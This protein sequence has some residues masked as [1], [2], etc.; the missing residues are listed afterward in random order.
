MP[1]KR[2]KKELLQGVVEQPDRVE[3][4][5]RAVRAGLALRKA[6]VDYGFL[7]AEH[8]SLPRAAV[9]QF[10]AVIRKLSEKGKQ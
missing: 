6:V 3:K 4:L 10:D 2:A 7:E 5:E 8:V 1:T 9:E